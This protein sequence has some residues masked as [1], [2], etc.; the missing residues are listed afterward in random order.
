MLAQI[1]NF[2]VLATNSDKK[3]ALLILEKG[4][5]AATPD[6]ALQKIIKKNKLELNSDI[7]F[8]SKYKRIFVIGLGKA[9]D[10]MAQSISSKINVNGGII[11]IQ[12][13]TN[14]MF[15]NKNFEI[16]HA[17]HPLPN[18]QSLYAAKKIIKFLRQKKNRFYNFFNIRRRFITCCIA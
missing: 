17:G 7:I 3:N 8:L 18:M 11:V 4:L 14:S 10:L 1:K 5:A 16:L 6:V 12:Q 9:A 15:K 13:N 2:N